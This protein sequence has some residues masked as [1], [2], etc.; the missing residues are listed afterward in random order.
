[1]GCK[2]TGIDKICDACNKKYYVSGWRLKRGNSRFC[3]T[4]CQNHI[5]YEKSKH[6]CKG[7]GK[8]FESSPCR[9]GKRIYCSKECRWS[10]DS[11]KEICQKELR[12]ER[13]RKYRESGKVPKNGMQ[14]RKYAFMHKEKEC[15]IC[16][17]NEFDCCL[18]I[19]H[20]DSN[21]NNNSLENL[22]VLCVMCHRK[23]HRNIIKL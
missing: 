23:V 1:M 6:K 17:F 10:E 2:R 11:K 3:S 21:P 14:L 18:D 13:I 20:V 7:C 12:R 22:A 5:Q 8:D 4:K 19:H 16:R 9:I 15:Q